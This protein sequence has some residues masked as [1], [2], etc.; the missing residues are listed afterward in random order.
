MGFFYADETSSGSRYF[1][2][3][4]MA[5]RESPKGGENK[6]GGGRQQL[7]DGYVPSKKG[8]QPIGSVQGGY[9]PPTSEGGTPPTGGGGGKEPERGSDKKD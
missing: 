6:G 7:N 4:K 5:D 9:Q 2:R 1:E 8:W 3:K